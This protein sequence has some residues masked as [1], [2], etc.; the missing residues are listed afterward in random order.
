[1]DHTGNTAIAHWGEHCNGG[2]ERVAWDLAR[3]FDAPLFVGSKD[4]DIGPDDI[5]SEAISKDGVLQRL[6]DHGGV[7]QMIGYQ[8]LWEKA[9]PLRDF[10]IVITSGNEP[11]AYVPPDGQ[12]WIAYI[13]HTSRYA[14]DL[15]EQAVSKISGPLEGPKKIAFRGIRKAERHIYSSYA[16]K[17]DRIVVNSEVVARRVRRYWGVPKQNISVVYPAVN[18]EKYSRTLAETDD[19]YL[20]LSRLDG[21]KRIDEVVTAFSQHPN[22]TLVVAG[23]GSERGRLEK[24]APDNVKF[25]GYV[26]ESEKRQLMSRAKGFVVNAE[27]ED[28]GITTVEALASGTPVIGVREGFTEYL[29]GEER[30]VTYVRG[31]LSDALY[32]IDRDGVQWTEEEIENFADRFSFERFAREM[33]GIVSKVQRENKIVTPWGEG[34]R[35]EISREQLQQDGNIK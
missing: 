31:E 19:I 10:E 18:V 26:S 16:Q 14:T 29:V 34:G 23:D 12:T 4:P 9:A 27:A 33:R 24:I 6:V 20:S 28:F 1:M 25:V 35:D 30:G 7:G 22:K 15:L 3:T 8:F 2:G 13:H 21:H 17:P 32:R 11:L 5:S